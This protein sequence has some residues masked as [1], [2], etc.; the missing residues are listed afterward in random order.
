MKLFRTLK[1]ILFRSF[2]LTYSILLVSFFLISG[3]MP[4]FASQ[5][6]NVPAP[7]QSRIV[8]GV[9]TDDTG[10]PLSGVNIVIK[11]TTNGVMTGTDGAFSISVP[12]DNAVLVFSYIG[13][14]RQELKVGRQIVINMILKE[15]TQ[16]IEEI[17]V[18]GYGTQSR[19]ML[20]SSISKLNSKV[21]ENIPYSNSSSALQG[22]ISGVRVQ[23]TTG[24]PGDAPRIIIRGGTS[25]NNPNGAGPLYI[26]DGV[27]APMTDLT[28]YDI[29]SIQVLKD[30]A[31]TSIYGARG[32]NGVVIITTK[33]GKAGKTRINYTYNMTVSKP[34]KLYK[35]ANARDFIAFNRLGRI[36]DP[37]YGDV[38]ASL[39][40]ATSF[41]TGNDL[42]NST[43][44]ILCSVII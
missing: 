25:I 7:N 9:V 33:T 16:L 8:K 13:F 5:E 24:Q 27:I 29:E 12:D 26:V 35:M 2:A 40:Q 18:I 44:F 14:V 43:L 41:G 28:G 4:I 22:A 37:K 34:G 3:Q 31:A 42:T 11:G 17:V 32:S 39:A 21:L 15:D 6:Y 38:T 23:N 20:T 30:A 1:R 10:D 36:F 19:E